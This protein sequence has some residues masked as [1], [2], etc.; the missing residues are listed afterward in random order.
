MGFFQKLARLISPSRLRETPVYWIHA[1][2]DRCGEEI[3]ARVNLYNDLSIEYEGDQASYHCRK[4][5]MGEGRCSQRIEVWLTF[6]QNR[7]L[8]DRQISGGTFIEPGEV[9]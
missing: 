7:Q 6:D 5:L 1:R 8:S 4:V 3:S 9:A 2:C